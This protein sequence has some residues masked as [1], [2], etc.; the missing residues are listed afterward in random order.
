MWEGLCDFMRKGVYAGS[1]DP[2]TLGH[3][4]IIDRGIR[5]FDEL[6]LA[7]GVNPDKRSLFTID[8][9]LEM[10]REITKGHRNIKVD[11]YENQFLVNYA[12]SINANYIL[13]G[14][15]SYKD[16]EYEN[17][18]RKINEDIDKEVTT[19]FLMPPEEVCGISS[20]LVKGLIG[21]EGW[22]KVVQKYVPRY[23]YRKLLDKNPGA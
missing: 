23:V 20:S 1:F 4:W 22:E 6:V 15:R 13:R 12:K 11:S 2:P 10:L 17:G 18:I 19:V 7:V 9:R 8:E 14:I 5:M 21:P 3:M 16:Y